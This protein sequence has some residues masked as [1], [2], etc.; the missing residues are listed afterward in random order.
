MRRR[1]FMALLGGLVACPT[2]ALAQQPAPPVIGFLSARSRSESTHLTVAFR[3]GL[4]DVGY[5]EGRNVTIEYRNA[6]D[7][8]DPQRLQALAVELNIHLLFLPSYSPNLNLIERLWGFAKRQSVYG[9]YH[10]TFASFRAAIEKT[11]HEIPTDHS[12]RLKTLMT[13]QFQKFD[14]VSLLA[15]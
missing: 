13:L 2:V 8:N 7:Q 4:N 1:E 5:I 12:D 14:D 9:K 3:K 10:A 6:E 11:L 15:A